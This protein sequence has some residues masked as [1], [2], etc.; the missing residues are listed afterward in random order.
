MEGDDARGGCVPIRQGQRFLV[1]QGQQGVF[2]GIHL[3]AAALLRSA[4]GHHVICLQI[5]QQEHQG[6][7]TGGMAAG[8]ADVMGL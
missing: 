7:G 5:L 1:L 4:H 8:V 6:S 3:P 2:L